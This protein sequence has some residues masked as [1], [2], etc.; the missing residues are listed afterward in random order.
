MA[1]EVP[2]PGG[3]PTTGTTATVIVVTWQGAELLPA[4]LAALR[5]QDLPAHLWVVDNASTDGTAALLAG[6]P[7]VRVLRAPRNL[8][9]AGGNDLALAQVTTPYA[10]LLNDDARPR[11]DWLRRLLAP[12]DEPGGGQVAAVSSQ[13][14]FAGGQRDGL[15]N[16]A[17]GLVYADGYGADRG[18][19]DDPDR[20]AEPA[21]VFAFCGTAVALRTAALAAVGTFDEEFFL[22][23]EDTDL[24]WRLRLAGWR[25]RYAPAAVT[26]HLHAASSGAASPLFVFSNDR[27]RLLM[28]TKCA[29]APRAARAVGRYLLTTASMSVR[30]L[31]AGR[32]GARLPLRLRVLASYA[33]LLPVALRHRR[34]IGRTA[35][36]PRR[37]L[38][39]E[40]VPVR[41]R[42]PDG[43]LSAAAP[44]PAPAPAGPGRPA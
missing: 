15:L 38:E 24:S 11:P 9:Y 18:F 40:L 20:W 6:E 30:D 29:T 19:G 7:G 12:F 39:R 22:Y 3:P 17:G 1:A 37:T 8:G 44:L 25:L 23:Y 26:E 35:V 16:S 5:A 27:N 34:R 14:L 41:L 28:L 4:C 42:R 43:G 33:R 13:V 10:V 2:P 32:P 31:R 21:D 36:V